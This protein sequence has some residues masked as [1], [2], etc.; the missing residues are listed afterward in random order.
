[1]MTG[2]QDPKPR[3]DLG[4]TIGENPLGER[5][6][7]PTYKF[8]K[9]VTETSSKGREPKAYDEAINDPIYRIR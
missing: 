2:P 5:L 4:E 9:L 8:A 1:M 6:V 3:T 7:R